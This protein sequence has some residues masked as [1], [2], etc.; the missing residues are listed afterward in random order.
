MGVGDIRYTVLQ[1][2]N[3]V[4]RKLGLTPTS[5]TTYNKVA[6]Q[7]V[8]FINDICNDLSDFGDWQE[9]LVTAN[10]TCHS[11]VRDYVINTSANIKNI[12]DFYFSGRRGPLR[13]VTIDDMRVM[14]R[15]T[16]YG[17]PTQFTIFGI[18]ASTAN[19]ILRVR[20]TPMPS[21]EGGL[22][23]ILYFARPPLYVAGTNDATVIPFPARIVV[24]GVLARAILNESEGAPT[25]RYQTTYQTY[26]SSR[27][28]ALNRFKGDTGWDTSFVPSRPRR[29]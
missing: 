2:V 16:A 3:E 11:S 7:Y 1:V 6:T 27:K 23:S 9:M 15:V 22:F 21:D 29:K 19:P 28:E 10:V 17:T 26:V 25:E 12:G 18:D 14:T 4:Q 13:N 24:L 5:S 20:P 8:D